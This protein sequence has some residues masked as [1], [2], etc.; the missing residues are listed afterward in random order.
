MF[1]SF[2]PRYINKQIFNKAFGFNGSDIYLI[3]GIVG[4]MNTEPARRI[5]RARTRK[6]VLQVK[7]LS[8]GTWVDV[9]KNLDRLSFQ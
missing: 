9:D 1:S 4:S 6:G 5:I 7:L 2:N 8:T 3:R